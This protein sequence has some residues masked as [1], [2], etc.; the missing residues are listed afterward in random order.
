MKIRSYITYILEGG[1]FLSPSTPGSPDSPGAP[2]SPDSPGA[3]GSLD[4]LDYPGSLDSL[5]YPGYNVIT[6]FPSS[7]DYPS[8]PDTPISSG[9]PR[10]PDPPP[11]GSPGIPQ[12]LWLSWFHWLTF[13]SSSL[14]GF[15][16]LAP[17]RVVK[18]P[19]NVS[20]KLKKNRNLP[21]LGFLK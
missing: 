14:S 8:Y 19:F 1:V 12:S 5:D 13:C 7:S 21:K 9:S 2:G 18:I 16:V 4:S 6:D 10:S 20:N 15:H 3:P 11:L 17:S